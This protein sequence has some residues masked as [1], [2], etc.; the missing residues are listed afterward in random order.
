MTN[1]WI[2]DVLEDLQKFTANNSMGRLADGLD[3]TIALAMREL[4]PNTMSTGT[5]V[6]EFEQARQHAGE[7]VACDNA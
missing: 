4:A 5:R 2:I 1:D 6:S 7:S 3:D